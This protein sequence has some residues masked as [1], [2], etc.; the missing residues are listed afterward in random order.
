MYKKILSAVNE[1]LNSEI[2]AR[3]A[4]SMARVCRAK[5]YLCFIASRGM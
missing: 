2:S 3:Y 4:L 5:F 1:H